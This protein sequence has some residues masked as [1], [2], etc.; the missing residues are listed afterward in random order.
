MQDVQYPLAAV[1]RTMKVQ[2]IVMRAM[3]KQISWWQAAEILGVSTRTMRRM[4][5]GWQKVG[6][7]GLFDRR[8]KKPSPKRVPVKELEKVLTLY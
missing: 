3:S 6:Y 2:E 5:R 1:E 8:R 4:R 7:D